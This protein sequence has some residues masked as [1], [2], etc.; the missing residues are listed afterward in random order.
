MAPWTGRLSP[1]AL[2]LPCRA[3]WKSYSTCP[4]STQSEL[5][6]TAL[7]N[8][9]AQIQQMP[10]APHPPKP[11]AP[12]R[13]ACV[14]D[15]SVVPPPGVFFLRSHCRSSCHP[16]QTARLQYHDP[17]TAILHTS[18]FFRL[19]LFSSSN[20]RTLVVVWGVSLIA[21]RAGARGSSSMV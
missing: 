11:P 9:Q 16:A 13:Y 4:P 21:I 3:W 10:G 17:Q 20:C 19:W 18:V 7:E 12:E 15:P 1:P 8:C 5:F 14:R 2:S 6:D